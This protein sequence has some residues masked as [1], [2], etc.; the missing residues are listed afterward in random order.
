MPKSKID[1][2]IEAK[3]A[4]GVMGGK[5]TYRID[6]KTIWDAEK[7]RALVTADGVDGNRRVIETRNPGLQKKLK[8]LG[9]SSTEEN[10]VMHS[11]EQARNPGI[12]TPEQVDRENRA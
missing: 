8:K 9:Y 3:Q 10:K 5:V 11:K 12:K 2:M 6:H 1:E 7:D 4:P